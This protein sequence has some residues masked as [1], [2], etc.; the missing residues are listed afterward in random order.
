M[1]IPHGIEDLS[2]GE[3]DRG[4]TPD[5]AQQQLILGRSDILQPE[6]VDILERLRETT[7]LRRGQPV[8]DVVQQ[9]QL[10]PDVLTHRGQHSRYVTQ[11]RPAVPFLLVGSDTAAGRFIA[12]RPLGHA[13]NSVQTR[14]SALGPYRSETLI[15][16]Y[17]DR[18]NELRSVP[19]EGM[20]VCQDSVACRTTEQ[21]IDGNP[22]GL[23]FDVPQRQIDGPDRG[24][25]HRPTPPIGAPIEILPG[26]LD[27]T[28][29]PAD[30]KRSHMVLQVAGDREFSAVE[31][32]V[33]PAHDALRSRD[34]QHD[35]VAPRAGDDYVDRRYLVSHS[36][37]SVFS[38]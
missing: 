16:K 4:L 2:D 7:R 13:I 6:E 17:V 9:H 1:A 38:P 14:N 33:A 22:Q 25:R 19:A 27:P 8:V 31:R 36:A 24:H 5:R 32:C 11:I 29:V 20:T 34:L 23:A 18:I 10:G 15:S 30:E 21:L 12:R 3:R 37:F 26:V 28:R 35:V